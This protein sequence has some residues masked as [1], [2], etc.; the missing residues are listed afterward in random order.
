MIT[1][2]CP[3]C[4]NCLEIAGPALQKVEFLSCNHCQRVVPSQ[5]LQ[6]V[7][8]VLAHLDYHQNRLSDNSRWL[9]RFD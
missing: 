5:F 6:N 1:F 2:I 4:E 8:H 7:Q 3:A 9:V